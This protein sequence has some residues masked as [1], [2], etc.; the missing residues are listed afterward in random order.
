M[1]SKRKL[2]VNLSLIFIALGLGIFVCE[3][4]GRYL[5]LGNPIIYKTDP[6]VGYRLKELQSKKRFK[7][8]KV[9]SDF[10]GFRYDHTKEINSDTKYIIFVGDSVT[11]GGSYIDDKD[12]F[13]SRY[14]NLINN[15]F[16]CLNNGVNSWGILNMGRFI[17]NI[18][19]YSKRNA[20]KFIL[21]ILPGDEAR[22]LRSIRDTPF[23]DG[24]PRQPS[25]IME[26]VRFLTLEKFVPNL[27]KENKKNK[28]N[29]KIS[30]KEKDL[31]SIQRNLIWD[32]LETLIEKSI[33]PIDIV[34]TP[35]MSWFIDKDERKE[36]EKYDNLL[37]NISRINAVNKTC[38][39]Y[40]FISSEYDKDIYHDGVHL[41]KKGHELW[42]KKLKECLN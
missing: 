29:S 20:E 3:Q 17:S 25:A 14:C 18:D 2:L 26:V 34:I 5:G 16:H 15:N 1:K 35:P 27:S 39:L 4:I 7:G 11:Y 33:Y 36:I 31:N 8:A 38:N 10:E 28:E 19:L 22:N 32:E 21:V 24:D 40:K 9:S 12:L 41:S 23:W 42:A 6:I 37:K 30:R 13:S